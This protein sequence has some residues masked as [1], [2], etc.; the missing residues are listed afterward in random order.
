MRLVGMLLVLV[1]ATAGQA[2]DFV[3]ATG[4]QAKAVIVLP[5]KPAAEETAAAA[6]LAT[7]LGQVT[8]GTFTTVAEDAAP[9]GARIH[10]GRTKTAL[11]VVGDPAKTEVDADTLIIRCLPPDRLLLLGRNPWGTQFAVSRFLYLY[12]GVRWYL[13][14]VDGEHVPKRADLGV[15][16][17]D[18][19]EQPAWLSRLWSAADR[20][21]KG[22]WNR[23]NLMRSRFSFHHYLNVWMQ[24]DLFEQ[25]PEWS[26]LRRN[27]QRYQPRGDDHSYNPCFSNPAVADYVAERI[28]AQFG[29]D[30]NL[31]SASIGVNDCGWQG[32][33]QCEGCQALD[34]PGKMAVH[35]GP[36][37]SNR[38]FT[39][40]N[41]VAEK[42]AVNYPDRYIGCLA[43]NACENPPTFKVH[44]MIVP[45]LT[46][47]RAQ[48]RD[49]EFA[50]ADRDWVAAWRA[51]CPSVAVY[52]YEYGSGYVIP[53]V[54]FH[55]SE[56]YLRY[57]RQ[58]QI[59]GWYAEI[60][61][62][63]A[64]DGPKA[65]LISQLLWDPNQKV[66]DLLADYYTNYFGPAR[67]PMKRYWELCERQWVEQEGK[68]VWFRYFFDQK[69]L[70]LFPPEVCARARKLLDEAARLATA[71]PYRRRIELTSKAFHMTELYSA[72]YHAGARPGPLTSAA[73]AQ[74]VADRLLNGLRAEQERRTYLA[75]VV[76]QEPLLKPVISFDARGAFSAQG[77]SPGTLWRLFTWC[78]SAKREDLARKLL[79]ELAKPDPNAE[80]AAVAKAMWDFQAVPPKNL[81]VNGGFDKTDAKPGDTTG[82]DWEAEG[83]P[84]GWSLWRRNPGEGKMQWVSTAKET[85]VRLEAVTGACFI[86]TVPVTPGKLYLL[87]ADYR[88]QVGAGTKASVVMSWKDAKGG[89]IDERKRSSDLTGEVSNTWTTTAVGAVAPENA[90]TAV[91]ML[92]ADNQDKSDR[93]AFDDLRMYEVP[94]ATAPD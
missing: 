2:A 44:P 32:Y 4:G 20:A 34:V 12:A 79:A 29:K 57:L 6:E 33:C 28:I 42:V 36:D 8:G 19:T 27:G 11:A 9:A 15:A 53:R 26:A 22:E 1:L 80:M 70:V 51:M 66:D 90:A 40:A 16:A 67:E 52:N 86:Q 48:W 50:Q 63:W 58:Q 61:C 30:P 74:A 7:Y 47:D 14:T 38:F 69:Q 77:A 92:F 55:L 5:A 65:W 73:Q 43:Y 81:M 85:Y 24:P 3:I 59:K 75:Q 23:R 13:P 31:L 25:H 17:V 89:W 35:G 84:P 87:L 83:A 18:R 37:Y 94:R 49:P 91:I 64:L 78:R 60:Y 39:F 56:Q 54:Y 68:A 21:D 76:E 46:N 45:Y 93:L 88:G 71:E 62:N 72:V 10:V 82:V 41:R